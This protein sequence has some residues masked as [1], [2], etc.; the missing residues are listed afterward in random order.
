MANHF[1]VI[2]A[3]V[4]SMG[5]ATCYE[6]AKAG[7]SVLGLE[8]HVLVND[9]ASHSGQTRIIRK[10]YFE[11]PDYVPLLKATYQ[12]WEA[13]EQVTGKS[14]YHP[15]GLAYFGKK[16]H[17]LLQSVKDSSRVY[18]LPLEYLNESATS[19][20][21]PDFEIP[22]SYESILEPEAGFVC[23]DQVIKAYADLAREHGAILKEQEEVLDWESQKDRVQINTQKG[24]YTCNKLILTGGAGNV[25]LLPGNM[26]QMKVTRQ[27]ISW[28]KPKNTAHLELG[29]LP[30]WVFAPD[31][32]QGIFYG[33]PM[34]PKTYGGIQGLKVAHHYPGETIDQLSEIAI[35]TEQQK[36]EAMMRQYMPGVFDGFLEVTSCLYTYSPDE[37]FVID[38]VPDT[39][40]Q[41]IAAAGFSGH[42]FK[43]V[44]VLGEVL[45]DMTINGKTEHLVDFLKISR[46]SIS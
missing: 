43:F 41:V 46:F 12:G 3:G 32:E 27:L 29:K 31:D 21:L 11:H 9:E 5:S 4:G 44:P 25:K 37:H 30:C 19:D 38:F 35:K 34:L 8:A 39:N 33:F 20:L 6:L 1:D 13:L 2:V 18:D 15:V 36:I 16:G 23:T 40:Q 17:P 26:P 10:A 45:R 28:V 42:G 22:K 14:F 7:L 24:S